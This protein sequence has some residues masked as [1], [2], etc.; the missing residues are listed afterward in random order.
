LALIVPDQGYF[1]NASCALN[2]ISTFLFHFLH[3][4][5]D[6]IQDRIYVLHITDL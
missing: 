4:T 3:I 1:R 2:L 6:R 5:K